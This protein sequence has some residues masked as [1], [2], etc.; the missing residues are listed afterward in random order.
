MRGHYWADFC[1][2]SGVVSKA[3]RAIGVAAREWESSHGE[4]G[5][6]TRRINLRGVISDVRC[7]RCLGCCLAPPCGT[8]SSSLFWTGRLRS[9]SE[10]WGLSRGLTDAQL[11]KVALSNIV[12]RSVLW[13]I[14]IFHRLRLPWI[15]ENPFSSLLWLLPQFKRLARDKHVKL[16][17]ADQCRFG[18]PWRKR[19]LF[20]CGNI[21]SDDLGRL[22]KTCDGTR[23][24]CP[25]RDGPH[26]VL[27]GAA[28]G[29]RAYTAIAAE[30]PPAMAKAIAHALTADAVARH[31]HG[32]GCSAAWQR[33]HDLVL[34]RHAA[35]HR[36]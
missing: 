14:G 12:V 7:G 6:I 13:L 5:D 33:D 16:V 36:Y 2:G 10:P 19:T 29:G 18:R 9:A 4:W 25:H 28:P 8:F 31:R 21:D 26:F 23:G 22:A 3:L 30:Y 15:C 17:T 35:R 20:M 32:S 1:S 11:K 34:H 27:Q 24:Y